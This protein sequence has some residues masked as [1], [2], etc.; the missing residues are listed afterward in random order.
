MGTQTPDSVQ[1]EAAER[2]KMAKAQLN[3][4][5]EAAEQTTSEFE[6]TAEDATQEIRVLI[7]GAADRA[8]AFARERPTGAL[9]MACATGALLAGLVALA[10]KSDRSA[11][12]FL[13]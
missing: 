7:R 13:D 2:A 1:V 4:T 6:R 8:F 9:L 12:S 5:V 3:D 10:L 11:R